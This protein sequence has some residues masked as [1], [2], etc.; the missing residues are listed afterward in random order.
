MGSKVAKRMNVLKDTN[1]KGFTLIELVVVI[2]IMAVLSLVMVPNLTAYLAKSQDAK[3]KANLKSLHTAVLITIQTEGVESGQSQDIK[4]AA[5][6]FVGISD[7]DMKEFFLFFIEED[8][9]IIGLDKIWY[10]NYSFNGKEYI[11]LY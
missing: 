2:A 7:D 6:V 4:D 5:Q 1:R 3:T 10:K 11:K 8:D 9:K